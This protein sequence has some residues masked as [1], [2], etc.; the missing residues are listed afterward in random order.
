[1]KAVSLT[2]GK[3]AFVDDEDF[4]WLS[5]WKWQ[6]VSKYAMRAFKVN[7]KVERELM[8][9]KIMNTPA[10]MDT[11]HKNGNK[12]D[13]QRKNLRICTR[14]ENE[15]NKGKTSRNTSGYMGVNWDMHSRKWK[16]MIKV[17]R[18]SIYLGLYQDVV[19]A[20]KAYDEAAIKYHGEFAY[21]NFRENLENATQG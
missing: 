18:E 20:A 14:S 6:Y 17:H 15:W 12:L 10:G 2:K 16:A 21:L 8:H 5:Q 9:R 19:Q 1:M 3:V 13:N 7:G 11:D 4:E